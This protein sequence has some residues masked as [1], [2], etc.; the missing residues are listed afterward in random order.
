MRRTTLRPE[1]LERIADAR[2]DTLA[3]FRRLGDLRQEFADLASASE[4]ARLEATETLLQ[5][6]WRPLSDLVEKSS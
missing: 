5:L 3:L 6:A 4:D 2:D 1:D